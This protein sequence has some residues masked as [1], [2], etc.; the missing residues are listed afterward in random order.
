M[1]SRLKLRL[2]ALL[3]LAKN[4]IGNWIMDN[5]DEIISIELADL[6]P[7]QTT[8]FV[9]NLE[10]LPLEAP[11]SLSVVADFF[12]ELPDVPCAI[13][14]QPINADEIFGRCRYSNTP[15]HKECWDFNGGCAVLGCRGVRNPKAF[16]SAVSL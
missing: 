10:D 14:H 5:S 4:K 3:P 9:I 7:E 8:D 6:P 11:V 15:Y 2:S 13:C 1:L 16:Q 12:L